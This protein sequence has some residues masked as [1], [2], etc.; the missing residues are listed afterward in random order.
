MT[1][2]STIAK[3]IAI[4][5]VPNTDSDVPQGRD[6]AHNQPVQDT[7][8]HNVR[9]VYRA[10]KENTYMVCTA[11]FTKYTRRNGCAWYRSPYEI[12]V[13]SSLQYLPE[14]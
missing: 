9:P 13:L 4:T 5:P 3:N 2:L 12:P 10:S 6:P 11:K 7:Q 8:R 1:I 14:Y